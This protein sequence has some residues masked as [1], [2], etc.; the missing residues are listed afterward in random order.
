M[1]QFLDSLRQHA[2]YPNNLVSPDAYQHT[3]QALFRRLNEQSRRLFCDENKAALRFW[4]CGDQGRG[5]SD[6]V[7]W[8]A[9]SFT[10]WLSVAGFQDACIC[11]IDDL[12]LHLGPGWEDPRARF[13]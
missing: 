1:E 13:M 9:L 2:D 3:L 6:L 11:D 7:R 12:E 4:E 5:K 8:W 10:D